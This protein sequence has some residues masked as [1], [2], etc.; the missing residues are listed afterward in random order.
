M[1]GQTAETVTLGKT[2][3]VVSAIGVGT[4][5]WG[6]RGQARTDLQSVFAGAL[7]RGITFFDT[8]EI[9][10]RG[11][12][13]RTLGSLLAGA[14]PAPVV[15]TKFFPLPWRLRRPA[16]LG[17]LRRSLERLGLPRV[18]VYMVHFP[19]P[20]VPIETWV[21]ALADA[22][23]AGLA[24]A[25][26]VS[27]YSAAQMR[28]AHAFLAARG[29]PLAC[30]EVEYNLL[31][32][33]PEKNGTLEA[34]RE[35]GVRL[36]AYRP[37][38][39]GFLTAGAGAGGAGVRGVVYGG[40]YARAVGGL[41]ALLSRIGAAHGGKSPSQVALNWLVCKGALPIPGATNVAHL[42]E[43]VGALGWRLTPEEA[44][45]LDA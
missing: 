10:G 7:A 6:A 22:V 20:P 24:R 12:S 30:N 39:L 32:R 31:R 27:N 13:E 4:N 40:G 18:D 25:V 45:A 36:I 17:A 19:T 8:A 42:E 21:E 5:R 14:N 38:A 23:H 28:R 43:N 2:G 41:P 33:D 11:G 34:C 15:L 37:L 29:V 3:L 9:Y 1:G 35:L 44:S 26:G 16:L